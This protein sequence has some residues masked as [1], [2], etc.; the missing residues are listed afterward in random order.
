M[1]DPYE[2]L[3]VSPSAT[4]EQIKAAYR[5][6][7]RKYHPDN[8]AN[9][10]LA[11][12]AQEKMKQ[13]NEAYDTIQRQRRQQGGS[14]AGY[15]SRSGYGPGSSRGGY[16]SYQGSYQSSQFADIRNLIN[17]RRIT[18]AEELLEGVPTAQ[19]DAEWNFL[20]GS[21][22]YTKGWLDEAYR[23]YVR[24]N[25]MAP[26]NPE[27]QAAL[28][29]LMWQRNTGRPGGAYGYGGYRGAPGG[30]SSDMCDLCVGLWCLDSCCECTGGDLIGCC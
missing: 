6:L 11:D 1:T 4:D 10:P 18:E 2:V 25:Q 29:Q 5:E 13:I 26:G 24:A 27:Y 20:R 22:F 17:S 9:N 16:Q 21:V 7:A 30:G 12:L 19:R 14:Q 23:C 8:Y 28:N 3:G 15:G